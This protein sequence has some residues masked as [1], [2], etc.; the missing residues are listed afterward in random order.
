MLTNVQRLHSEQGTYFAN[1][2]S[3]FPL[4][5]PAQASIQTGQY[6]HNHG[7]LGNGGALWPIGGYQALDQTNTLAVWLAAAG[8][9]TA[10]VGKPMV[11]YN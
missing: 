6:P 1:S 4:C 5:C 3:S 7:V 8:Y 10:F 9:Q 2:F 11:G